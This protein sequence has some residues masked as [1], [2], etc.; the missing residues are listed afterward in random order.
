M[1]LFLLK[2]VTQAPPP[3][4]DYDPTHLASITRQLM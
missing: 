3:R 1:Q 4:F 2:N